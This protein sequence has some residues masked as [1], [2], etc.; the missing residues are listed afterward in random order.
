MEDKREISISFLEM[1][2]SGNIE[3]AFSKYIHESFFHHNPYFQGD[4][5]SLKIGMIE[6]H[7]KNPNKILNIFQIIQ[8]NE[9]VVV[10]SK[11][12]L[13]QN[14]KELNVLHLFRFQENKIIEMWDIGTPIPDE[15]INKNGIF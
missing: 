2:V 9:K 15:I 12:T 5:E 10:H 3:E 6:N 8:E 13:P 14:K 4:K 1:I 11:L 7:S